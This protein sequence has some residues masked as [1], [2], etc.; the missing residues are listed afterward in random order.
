MN[1]TE[2]GKIINPEALKASASTIRSF[3]AYERY[4][5]SF[6]CLRP[7]SSKEKGL[8][9]HILSHFDE[10][11]LNFEN[12]SQKTWIEQFSI[13]PVFSSITPITLS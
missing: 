12:Y 6:R 2:I 11:G 3:R 4:V 7:A 10:K 13:P 1:I 5:R 9:M 8:K